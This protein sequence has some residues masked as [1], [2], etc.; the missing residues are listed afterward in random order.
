MNWI[1]S[2]YLDIVNFWKFRKTLKTEEDNPN[3]KFNAFNLKTN[4]LRNVLYKNV[5]IPEEFQ[6]N[7]PEHMIRDK[8]LD[9]VKPINMYLQNEL[10]W[11]EYLSFNI[12]HFTDEE[13]KEI[14]MDYVVEWKYYPFMLGTW[15]FWRNLSLF[16]FFIIGLILALSYGI[17][18][19]VF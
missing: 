9:I 15:R 3:S 4:K 13:H 14:I 12:W 1:R 8:I 11:G 16:A 17:P 5:V 6:R 10:I 19:F 7:L 2:T 18:A